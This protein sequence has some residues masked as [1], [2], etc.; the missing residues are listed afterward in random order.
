VVEGRHSHGAELGHMKIEMTAPRLC[1]CGRWG[2][3]EAYASATAVTRR[4]LEALRQPGA[5]SELSPYRDNTATL[6]S[7]A[8]FDAAGR[9][10]ALAGR[11]VDETAKYLALAAANLMH[12][13]N[14]DIVVF[15]GGMIAAG[16]GFL[17]RIRHYVRQFAFPVPAE[18]TIV[19][20]A[21]LGSDAGFVGAAACAR[22]VF[23][24]G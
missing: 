20:Y 1:G 11:I 13:I 12:V 19:C 23:R 22:Q 7:R 4:T 17:S 5:Q 21:R 2:C 14:P 3:L 6:T 15:G 24:R 10:D 18:R 16:D 9:G 8:V